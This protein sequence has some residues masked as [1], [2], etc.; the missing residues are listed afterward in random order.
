V[1]DINANQRRLIMSIEE[2][3]RE[4][5]QLARSKR[6]CQKQRDKIGAKFLNDLIRDRKARIED[7]KRDAVI[8]GLS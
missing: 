4:I 8:G 7:L 1:G 2:I 5:E 6:R 3:N